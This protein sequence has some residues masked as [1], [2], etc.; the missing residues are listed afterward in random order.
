MAILIVCDGCGEIDHG[1]EDHP[2]FGRG[3]VHKK[4]FCQ[5]CGALADEYFVAFDV[6]H[7][8]IVAR[9]QKDVARLKRDFFKEHPDFNLPD[10]V[11]AA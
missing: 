8:K 6:L 4:H 10:H 1:A 7:D 11:D 3:F 2:H 5:A 9:F